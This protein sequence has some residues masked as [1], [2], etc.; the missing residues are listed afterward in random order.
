MVLLSQHVLFKI[1]PYLAN[2]ICVTRC[3]WGGGGVEEDVLHVHEEIPTIGA[4]GGARKG[5][6][7]LV[8]I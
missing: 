6:I 4:V 8:Q 3:L 7:C 2:S 5:S 1:V